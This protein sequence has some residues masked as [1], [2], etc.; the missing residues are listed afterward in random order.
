MTFKLTCA[1]YPL[2]SIKMYHFVSWLYLDV[3]QSFYM[4]MSISMLLSIYIFLVFIHECC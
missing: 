3:K 2:Y 4:L 1:I